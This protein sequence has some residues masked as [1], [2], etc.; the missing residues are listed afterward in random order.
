MGSPGALQSAR[1][2]PAEDPGGG[3]GVRAGVLTTPLYGRRSTPKANSHDHVGRSSSLGGPCARV[4]RAPR[5]PLRRHAPRESSRRPSSRTGGY[6]W[7]VW[8]GLPCP[9]VIQN[10][11]GWKRGQ[12]PPGSRREPQQRRH[13]ER[14]IRASPPG[15]ADHGREG[16]RRDKRVFCRCHKVH[17]SYKG[18]HTWISLVSVVHGQSVAGPRGI[19]DQ[20][21]IATH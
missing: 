2:E 12:T 4:V 10:P 14:T 9:Y 11:R 6:P 15:R 8:G 19:R 13:N 16:G 21:D 17:G 7:A 20:T 3:A 1:R 18:T 5:L